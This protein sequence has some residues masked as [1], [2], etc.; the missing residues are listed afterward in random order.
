MRIIDMHLHVQPWEQLKPAV[1]TELNERN[2]HLARA[3]NWLNSP[4]KFLQYLDDLN[5]EK[6]ALINVV[7]P[8]LMGLD[9]STNDFVLEYAR[10]APDRFI[11]FGSIH[12]RFCDDVQGELSRLCDAGI[13]CLKLHPALQYF[14]PNA[15]R[16]GFRDLERIYSRAEKEGMLLMFHTGASDF[17]RARNVYGNPLVI[18]DIA[19][20]FPKLKIVLAHGGWPLFTDVAVYLVSRHPN[21]YLDLSGIP[22]SDLL[23]AF[24]KLKTIATKTLWG[25]NWP[26]FDVKEPKQQIEAFKNLPLHSSLQE[27]ILY[28]N[29]E[30]LLSAI[31]L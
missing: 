6:V 5:I 2:S 8:D 20:D 12:P 31:G 3:M 26:Y 10:N 27:L 15:Y 28:E 30:A 25:S 17:P 14:I 22:A 24:P 11:P 13:R 23:T 7:S 21:V 4:M 29:A 9:A 1:R 18:D 19:V 16:E